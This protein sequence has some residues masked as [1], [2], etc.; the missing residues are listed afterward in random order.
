[1]AEKRGKVTA[2][3]ARTVL[4]TFFSW[5]IGKRYIEVNPTINIKD[6]ASGDSRERVL[7]EEEIVAVWNA[8]GDAH[9]F[10][11]VVRLLLLTGCR[12]NGDR[13]A[14]YGPRSTSRSGRSSCPKR[15]R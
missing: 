10:G 7:S 8:A 11:K 4:S 6:R 1:M 3:R 14:A 9:D 13:R 12:R 5:V 2:D 15:A